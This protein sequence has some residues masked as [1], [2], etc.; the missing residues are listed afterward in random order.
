[1]EAILKEYHAQLV[2]QNQESPEGDDNS[3]G[4]DPRLNRTKKKM[5]TREK[6]EKLVSDG[7]RNYPAY[8]K[9]VHTGDSDFSDDE[10]IER[11]IRNKK[12][13]KKEK[14]EEKQEGKKDTRLD[15]EEIIDLGDPPPVLGAASPGDEK[16]DATKEQRLG[17]D[18]GKGNSTCL[19]FLNPKVNILCVH[20]RRF[21]STY[22]EIKGY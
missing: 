6:I 7:A 5:K 21:F 17:K 2:A 8:L 15:K 1:M 3:D 14:K 20:S 16:K 10:T 11:Q 22:C 4:A 12:E 18:G 9:L 19:F 13:Q